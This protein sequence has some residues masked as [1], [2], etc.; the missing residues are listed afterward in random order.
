MSG[1]EQQRVAIARALLMKPPLVLADE[2]TGN[3]DSQSGNAVLELLENACR[4]EGATLL[5]VTHDPS[6]AERADRVIHIKDGLL[7]ADERR[8]QGPG[9]GT[10]TLPRTG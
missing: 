3:L 1:G 10:G 4:Q 6:I 2:P 9:T 5:L 7:A 8:A